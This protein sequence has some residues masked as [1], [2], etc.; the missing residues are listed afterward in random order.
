MKELIVEGYIVPTEDQKM[1]DWYGYPAT[2]PGKLRS[3]LKEAAGEDV[4]LR[5]NSYGGD[6]WAAADM[7][8]QLKS[9]QGNSEAYIPG[10]AAS[11]ATI[12]MCGAK[13]VI[14]G[15]AGQLM[16]H[17]TQTWADGDYREMESAAQE[18][19]TGNEAIINVYA[20]KTGLD[21]S[22][23]QD[24]MDRQ[25]W[26]SAAVAV[27]NKFADEIGTRKTAK[28]LTNA[29]NMPDINRMRELF[30]QQKPPEDPAEDWQAKATALLDI[31]QS[32]F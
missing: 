32:R 31:E 28:P 5:I 4:S 16:I 12:M 11:A 17:N 30:A 23:L 18:A 19:R 9:Y 22:V 13:K 8:D 26:M 7:C 2:S 27:E 29:S 3:F 10:L 1:Y 15:E 20:A 24:L 14:I 21:R 6:V 25:T